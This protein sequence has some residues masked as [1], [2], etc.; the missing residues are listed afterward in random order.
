[1]ATFILS[2]SNGKAPLIKK[3][4]VKFLLMLIFSTN[5]NQFFCN[6]VYSSVTGLWKGTNYFDKTITKLLI[7]V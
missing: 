6:F 7:N 1:M 4:F 3:I 2:L 5:V